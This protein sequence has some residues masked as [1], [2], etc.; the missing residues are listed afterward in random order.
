VKKDMRLQPA[1]NSQ[2]FVVLSCLVCALIFF[3]HPPTYAQQTDKIARIGYLGAF[4]PSAG[5]SLLEAFRQGLGELVMSRANI[6]IDYRWAEGKPDRLPAAAAELVN[7]RAEIIVTQSNAAVAALQQATKTIPIIVAGMGDP[8]ESGFV[9][10][11]ARPGRNITGFS[12]QAEDFAG[13]WVELLTQTVP[14]ISRVAVLAVSQTVS[15]ATY[16]REIQ[17]TAQTLKVSPQRQDLA[18]PDDIDD[19]FVRLS[20]ARP[21]GVIVL[22]HAITIER[23]LQIGQ[24]A[25]KNRLP[26]I[27]AFGLFAEAG[28]LMSYG[29]NLAELHRRAATYVNKILKGASPAELPVEQPTKFELLINLTAAKQIGLTIP[30]SVLA[31]A[32]KVIK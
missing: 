27:Y 12:N 16:W 13:K 21:Q 14:K 8:V 9:A 17:A 6:F 29:T 10:S 20:K 32:D 22:P 31:R 5:A 26:A 19:A 1:G 7:L 28:G 15:H 11:L 2:Q 23:R 30:P 18:G 3:L 24:L 4:T 25:T